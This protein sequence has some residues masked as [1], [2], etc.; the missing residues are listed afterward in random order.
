VASSLP[1]LH[2][3]AVASCASLS[4]RIEHYPMSW[5]TGITT[6]THTHLSAAA[7]A[8][9]TAAVLS[10]KITLYRAVCSATTALSVSGSVVFEEGGDHSVSMHVQCSYARRVGLAAAVAQQ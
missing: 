6:H 3:A 9:A 2:A 8:A 10:P 5:M 1:T 4:S 7:A